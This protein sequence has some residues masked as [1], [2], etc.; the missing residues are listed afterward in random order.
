MV[1]PS[2]DCSLPKWMVCSLS[3]KSATLRGG[4][5]AYISAHTGKAAACV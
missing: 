2:A 5:D 4:A 3:A 1:P